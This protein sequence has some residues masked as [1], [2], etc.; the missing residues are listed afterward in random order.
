[1][2]RYDVT[3]SRV[4]RDDEVVKGYIAE[5]SVPGGKG[6]EMTKMLQ[7]ADERILM[8]FVH[9]RYDPLLWTCVRCCDGFFSHGSRVSVLLLKKNEYVYSVGRSRRYYKE[10]VT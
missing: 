8:I 10:S 4:G 5:P 3:R 1:M 7:V 6:G 9:V 2:D